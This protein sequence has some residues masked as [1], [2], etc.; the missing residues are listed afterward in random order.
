MDPELSSARI[1][2]RFVPE[3]QRCPQV[4]LAALHAHPACLDCIVAI[5][6]ALWRDDTF[7]LKAFALW[8]ATST[9]PEVLFDV[10]WLLDVVEGNAKVQQLLEMLDPQE[11]LL[12]TDNVL[13]T[14][15]AADLAKPSMTPRQETLALALL[16]DGSSPYYQS[17]ELCQFLGPPSRWTK[18]V[19]LALLRCEYKAVRHC[20]LALP[21]AWTEDVEVQDALLAWVLSQQRNKRVAASLSILDPAWRSPR[22]LT[23]VAER[24][25]WTFVY[26]SLFLQDPGFPALIPTTG[27]HADAFDHAFWASL[28]QASPLMIAPC[29]S[30][31][32]EDLVTPQAWTSAVACAAAAGVVSYL[33]TFVPPEHYCKDDVCA[34]LQNSENQGDAFYKLPETLRS[35]ADVAAHLLH[36]NGDQYKHCPAELQAQPDFLLRLVTACPPLLTC[37]AKHTP[38]YVTAE[39]VDAVLSQPYGAWFGNEEGFALW[40]SGGLWDAVPQALRTPERAARAAAHDPRLSWWALPS[41]D[42]TPTHI[43][44]LLHPPRGNEDPAY[45]LKHLTHIPPSMRSPALAQRFLLDPNNF[46]LSN[47]LSPCRPAYKAD[48]TIDMP[49]AGLLAAFHSAS[50]TSVL[51]SSLHVLLAMVQRVPLAMLVLPQDLVLSE[52]TRYALWR[53]ATRAL[54]SQLSGCGHAKSS[55]ECGSSSLHAMLIPAADS[56]EFSFALLSNTVISLVLLEALVAFTDFPASLLGLFLRRVPK[57]VWRN[58]PDYVQ[59]AVFITAGLALRALP[60]DVVTLDHVLHMMTRSSRLRAMLPPA[61]LNHPVIA[62][63]YK[64]LP[65]PASDTILHTTQETY[66]IS[67]DSSD[68]WEYGEADELAEADEAA[69]AA[70]ADE[71]DEADDES[72]DAGDDDGEG[73]GEGATSTEDEAMIVTA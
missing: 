19:V 39:L 56:P 23:Q 5:P 31:L 3:H 15:M 48:G 18:A 72:G 49:L 24:L 8:H 27:P 1:C 38:Q 50:P 47:A 54:L 44:Q 69:E 71:A 57:Q 61:W 59:D 70:E 33:F 4:C 63:T 26:P 43:A 64:L 2:A 51:A 66:S 52:A 30:V 73:H 20:I 16:R 21:L 46:T 65:P 37:I 17:Q 12:H 58:H 41:E 6:R 40:V 13:P 22:L 29:L 11:L 67:S 45:T 28:L 10:K 14:V 42:L 55:D 53:D 9:L 36:M 35:D 34:A 68:S 60:A 7:C 62:G 32:P 25:P